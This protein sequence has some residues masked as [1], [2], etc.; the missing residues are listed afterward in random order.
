[1]TLPAGVTTPRAARAFVSAWLA[2]W[3]LDDLRD[4]AE[5]ATS[6]LVTNAVEHS[7]G[8]VVGVR[9]EVQDDEVRVA[10]TDA[11]DS[12][13]VTRQASETDQDGRGLRIVNAICDDWGTEPLD[14][15]GKTIWC[16]FT[17]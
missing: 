4:R 11:Q 7:G 14:G 17:R 8:S 13:P 2:S 9:I 12:M 15:R 3:E 6:E 16:T 5:L 1:M 10:V